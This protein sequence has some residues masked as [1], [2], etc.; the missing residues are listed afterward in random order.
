[1]NN[2][3]PSE[4]D[5]FQFIYHPNQPAPCTAAPFDWTP[6]DRWSNIMSRIRNGSINPEPARQFQ[7]RICVA[8]LLSPSPA[9]GGY[10]NDTYTTARSSWLINLL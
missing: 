5:A 10:I 9:S 4:C 8:A 6:R 2:I 1:M 7:V 3:S